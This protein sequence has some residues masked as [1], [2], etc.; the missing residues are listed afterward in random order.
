M[1]RNLIFASLCLAALAGAIL[2]V[3]AGVVERPKPNVIV[4]TVESARLDALSAAVTPALWARAADAHRFPSHRAVSAWTAANIVSLLTGRH[5]ADHGV[6]RRGESVHAAGPDMVG[7]LK[8]EGWEVAGLQAFMAVDVFSGFGLTVEPGADLRYWLA[9]KAAD[10]APFVLWYHYLDTHLPYR[11][12]HGHAG[13]WQA[14]LPEGDRAAQARVAAVATMPAIAK[15]AVAFTA[16]DRPAI[17]ALYDGGFR[18]F[19]AWFAD[20]W[21]FFQSSGLYRNTILIV[22]AD[23][24][25]EL[26]ERGNVGHASTTR[27]GHLYE[28]IVRLPLIIWLPEGLTRK[29]PDP[30]RGWTDHLDLMPTLFDLL[31]IPVPSG[32]PGVSLYG[33]GSRSVWR[34]LTTPGG[35]ADRH[36][37]GEPERFLSAVFDGRWKAHMVHSGDQVRGVHLFDL[38]EDPGEQRDLAAIA[39]ERLAAMVE[40]APR[41]VRF[42]EAPDTREAPAGGKPARPPVWQ[43]PAESGSFTYDDIDGRVRFAWQGLPHAHYRLQYEVGRG[44]IGF[45][46]EIDVAG[47]EMDFGRIDRGYWQQWVVPYSPYRVR[48]GYAGEDP[49][50]SPWLELEAR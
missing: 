15:G 29:R 2:W 33:S 42:P 5:P 16:A 44:L 10:A 12:D 7:R 8:R 28:E 41:P 37:A 19:D 30:D 31:G 46:G 9:R 13:D 21:T 40:L 50:W 11:D 23:H 32:L 43:V 6:H 49:L 35:Y 24:G 25:E 27:D 18:A 22:T 4:L 20:F 17:R 14:L 26:L 1:S 39:P 45:R 34:A 3:F 36:Q 48:V 47:T 38:A